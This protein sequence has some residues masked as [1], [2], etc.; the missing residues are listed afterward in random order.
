MSSSSTWCATSCLPCQAHS[1][2]A[3]VC[4]R[5]LCDHSVT[6]ALLFV[7]CD[8]HTSPDVRSVRAGAPVP[9][10]TVS[11]HHTQQGRDWRTGVLGVRCARVCSG[12]QLPRA[13]KLQHQPNPPSVGTPADRPTCTTFVAL[14]PSTRSSTTTAPSKSGSRL[15]NLRCLT[16]SLRCAGPLVPP[17]PRTTVRLCV[18]T[19]ALLAPACCACSAHQLPVVCFV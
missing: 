18:E 12:N 15:S 16:S 6:C 2:A 13:Y 19:T 3:L 9:V 1:A 4:A 17:L 10:R 14:S 11:K 5:G 8:W 7:R